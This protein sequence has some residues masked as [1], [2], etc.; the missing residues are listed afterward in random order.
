MW[1]LSSHVI[2]G[3][4][5]EQNIF[6]MRGITITSLSGKCFSMCPQPCLNCKSSRQALRMS[7]NCCC[8]PSSQQMYREIG[9]LHLEK[10]VETFTKEAEL[11]RSAD[12]DVC[13][14]QFLV[15]N[16]IHQQFTKEGRWDQRPK[17]QQRERLGTLEQA[18]IQ[19]TF[20]F[21]LLRTSCL[22]LEEIAAGLVAHEMAGN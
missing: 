14:I 19:Q 21:I 20:P 22:A 9:S 11:Q 12:P 6:I 7:E 2:M 4:L 16:S 13:R 3:A 5:V 18:F 8:C 10:L 15:H 17:W 1:L